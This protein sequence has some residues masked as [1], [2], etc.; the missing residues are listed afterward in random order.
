MIEERGPNNV[1]RGE[2]GRNG[3]LQERHGKAFTA[4]GTLVCDNLSEQQRLGHQPYLFN[5][6]IQRKL[7][8]VR[9][10]SHGERGLARAGFSE[11]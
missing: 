6:F 10:H 3:P 2:V 9:F 4:L 11:P 7:S 5:H 8:A 1:R